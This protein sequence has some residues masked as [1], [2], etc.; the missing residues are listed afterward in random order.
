MEKNLPTNTD[1][2][3]GE[4]MRHLKTAPFFSIFIFAWISWI[5]A[6]LFNKLRIPLKIMASI[7]MEVNENSSEMSKGFDDDPS[8]DDPT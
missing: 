7:E 3:T 2:I 8:D 1:D 4:N 5:F 6:S